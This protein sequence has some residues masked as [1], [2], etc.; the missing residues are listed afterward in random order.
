MPALAERG[1]AMPEAQGLVESVPEWE[2]VESVSLPW[3]QV[4]LGPRTMGF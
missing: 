3:P 1:L 4:Q 2:L